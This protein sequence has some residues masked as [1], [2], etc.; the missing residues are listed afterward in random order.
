[1]RGFEEGYCLGVWCGRT[2]LCSD[3][4]IQQNISTLRALY[5]DWEETNDRASIDEDS[6][7]TEFHLKIFVVSPLLAGLLMSFFV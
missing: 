1:M 3:G 7:L 2:V 6:F 5:S 4:W